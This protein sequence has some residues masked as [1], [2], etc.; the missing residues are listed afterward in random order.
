MIKISIFLTALLMTGCG[1]GK[2][3]NSLS[4]KTPDTLTVAF[5]NV[6]N[7]FDLKFDGLEYPEY[8]PGNSNWD[9]VM[10]RKKVENMAQVIAAINADVIALCEVEN[11]N[12]LEE[13]KDAIGIRGIKYPY[14]ATGDQPVK[15][16]TCTAVLSKYPLGNIKGIPVYLKGGAK[17]RNIL[18]ADI[19]IHGRTLKVFV[20]HWPSKMAP[21]SFRFKAAETLLSRIQGITA[22]KD[23]VIL[24]D[25]NCDYDEYSKLITFG[26]NDTQGK[27]GINNVLG[28]TTGGNGMPVRFVNEWELK[29]LNH[30]DL[31]LELPESDRR[32]Y[33]FKGNPQTPD[34]ILLPSAL[35]DSTGFS[36]LDNSF[37]AFTWNGEL[38]KNNIPF[39]WRTKWKRKRKLHVG[40]GYSDHLPLIARFVSRPFRY[41]STGI[42]FSSTPYKNQDCLD[43]GVGFEC[44][45]DG[46]MSCN[47]GVE[48]SRDTCSAEN[49]SYC[50]FI[51]GAAQKS[52]CS[53][54]RVVLEKKEK[55]KLLVFDFKGSGKICF[56]VRSRGLKW[57]YYNAGEFKKSKSARYKEVNFLKWKRLTLRLDEVPEEEVEF[58]IRAG[59]G[60][61]FNLWVDNVRW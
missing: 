31:W 29:S 40:E 57:V 19:L 33:V 50:L 38:L 32:S 22:G 58:E 9:R 30:Y 28:T 26:H 5:Y 14:T 2:S 59:K 55:G 10:Q 48:L 35:F 43:S 36:Y 47:S 25:F 20:N 23:Y 21:E 51:R 46:W 60:E 53:A 34:H 52:S 41:D 13:L 8:K 39:R 1:P 45:T 61:P 15:T 54:A 42:R 56:R 3:D 6:E 17:T 18:E 49:G 44:S 16:I 4:S 11:S 27:T 37:R 12:A 24:G 7:L